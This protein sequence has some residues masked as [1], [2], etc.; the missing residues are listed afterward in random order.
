MSDNIIDNVRWIDLQAVAD[1]RG[2]L[3]AIESNVDIPFEVKRVFYMHHIESDRG[4]H[5]HLETDQLAIG[6][7]GRHVIEVEDNTGVK[8]FV[9]DDPNKGLYLP[10]MTFTRLIDFSPGAV[11]LVLASSHY[12]RSKSIRTLEE[13]KNLLSK[14]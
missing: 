4:G 6:I 2:T 1:P 11:C 7:S 9:M 8:S 5:A 3:T 10:R 14:K 12:D 13:Y